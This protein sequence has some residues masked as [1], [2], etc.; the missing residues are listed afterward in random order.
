MARWQVT[1]DTTRLDE[2]WDQDLAVQQG[3][4]RREAHTYTSLLHST[5]WCAAGMLDIDDRGFTLVQVDDGPARVTTYDS[6]LDASMVLVDLEAA[7]DLIVD[8]TLMAALRGEGRLL[9][10]TRF[11][12]LL[13]LRRS[14]DEPCPIVGLGDHRR[15]LLV[16]TS[17]A[18]A[19]I[20]CAA[21]PALAT[22]AD[23]RG[24]LGA[25]APVPGTTVAPVHVAAD[26]PAEAAV[27]RCYAVACGLPAALD[28][29]FEAT[30]LRWIGSL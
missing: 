17:P 28:G 26:D 1:L 3:V 5:A 23:V 13:E 7:A 14:T 20:A 9:V 18:Q 29:D 6:D 12:R 10:A 22:C 19:L 24:L 30:V 27:L 25:W 16:I 15:E 21:M 8:R 4:D 2:L 11:D